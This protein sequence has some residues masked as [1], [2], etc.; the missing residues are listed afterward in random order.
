MDFM[1]LIV[2]T[3]AFVEMEHRVTASQDSVTVPVASQ[4]RHVKNVSTIEV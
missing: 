4:E 1:E 3:T 2:C